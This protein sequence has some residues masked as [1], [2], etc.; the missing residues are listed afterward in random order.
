MYIYIYIYIRRITAKLI[1]FFAEE[2]ASA[3][4]FGLCQ[5]S[6]LKFFA[7]VIFFLKKSPSKVFG[8]ILKT[9]QRNI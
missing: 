5:T 4:E 8:K 1:Y 6:L 9:T 7:K 2:V 3:Y